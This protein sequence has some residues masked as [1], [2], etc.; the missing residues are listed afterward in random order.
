[1][2][3]NI[4]IP[5]GEKKRLLTAGKYCAE[6]IIVESSGGAT[7][8][9]ST[10]IALIDR[11][12]EEIE[13]PEGV[14]VIGDGA[15]SYTKLVRITIPEGV[16]T[17]GADAFKGC[18]LLE[19]IVFPQSLESLGRQSLMD[20][21]LIKRVVIPPKVTV[22][23]VTF[24]SSCGFTEFIAEGDIKEINGYA[25]QYCSKCKK[26]DFTNCTRVP[27]LKQTTAFLYISADCKI[28]VPASLYDEWVVA[29]NWSVYA[30]HIVAKAEGSE[31]LAYELNF[32]GDKYN[33]VGMG[34]CT[35]SDLIIPS[36]YN[37]LPVGMIDMSAFYNCV[38]IE[39]VTI[40]DGVYISWSA[41]QECIGL[42]EV[43]FKGENITIGGSVFCGCRSL[44]SI[45]LPSGMGA[46]GWSLFAG[47]DSLKLIDFTSFTQV[48]E[49]NSDDAFPRHEG[50]VIKVPA[51]LYDE[52]V[53]ATN[54]TLYADFIVA[55]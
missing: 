33:V 2:S 7:A 38:E 54:W 45:K 41:F 55:V 51:S 1:M 16:V 42:K 19:E 17:I 36:T 46:I 13:I 37:G 47:C 20:C 43:I 9:N 10:L 31:G 26:Y 48:P 53:N 29:T 40:P 39:R 22:I 52:W 15:F 5:A 34:S 21:S 30:D 12:I 23:P 14:E 27:T 28:L 35:D 25:L 24:A 50:L 44:E 8:D 49:M 11:S 32:N 6:D 18:S 4:I 3:I